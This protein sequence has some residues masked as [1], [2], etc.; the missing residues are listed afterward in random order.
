MEF[1]EHRC[2]RCG[3]G[4]ERKSG[5]MWKCQYCGN[6]YDDESAAKHMKTLK[7][8]FDEEKQN[9]IANLR[10]NLYDAVSA[11]YISSEQVLGWCRELKKLLPEDFAANF[12]EVAAS[13]NVKQITAY[14]REIDADEYY[15]D[16][17]IV[18]EFL[19]RSLQSEYLLELN[20]L[21]DRT[22]KR[23]NLSTFEKYATMLSISDGDM[24][25]HG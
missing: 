8:L 21:I 11:E 2:K 3:G 13:D 12:Y 1:I 24:R 23:R 6:T 20:N 17:D 5:S 4:L 7:E 25:E 18:I 16:M 19:I 10:R 9:I 14:I 15:E 22:Y